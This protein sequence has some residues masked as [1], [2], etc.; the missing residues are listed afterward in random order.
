M[1][2]TKAAK[3]VYSLNEIKYNEVNKATAI[4]AWIPIVGFILL[5][6]E[7]DDNFVKY[8]GAQSSILGLLEMIAWVPV[9]GWLIAPVTLILI[10]VG[11]VKSSQG[12]RF[13][14]PLISDLALKVMG[15]FN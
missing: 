12:E 5:L 3:K 2:E 11:M 15:W 9:I 10:I 13:D 4:L 8:N 1:A 14:I 7:K 6:V